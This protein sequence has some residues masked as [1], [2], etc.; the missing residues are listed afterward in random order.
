[1]L[2]P[3]RAAARM[4]RWRGARGAL[5][6][7]SRSKLRSPPRCPGPSGT[8]QTPRASRHPTPELCR[9]DSARRSREFRFLHRAPRN[10][11][12][13]FPGKRR[14]SVADR[15]APLRKSA[16][17]PGRPRPDSSPTCFAITATRSRG[18]NPNFWYSA[19]CF[20]L[21]ANVKS[22]RWR[23]PQRWK[24]S[25]VGA[26][27]CCATPRFQYS[28]STV[29]GPKK[30]KLPQLVAKLEPISRPACS[31]AT[32]EAGSV[33]QRVPATSLSR[34]MRGSSVGKSEKRRERDA[35]DAARLVKIAVDE[36]P[37]KDVGLRLRC[38]HGTIYTQDAFAGKP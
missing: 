36:R 11:H 28:G 25:I 38:G 32:T 10:S 12:P 33:F 35:D 6:Q 9:P 23:L 4:S 1:M 8:R 19:M 27:S 14:E 17:Y 37:D 7:I 16:S 34:P 24:I 22:P 31:A 5:R 30:P 20:G 21:C 18:Q 29:S 15:R 13:L 26:R 3:R 2:R